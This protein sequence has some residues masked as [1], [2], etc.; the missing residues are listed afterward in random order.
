MKQEGITPTGGITMDAGGPVTTIVTWKIQEG[1]EQQF[2]AW[3]HEIEAAATKFPGH[4]GVNL[5]V[6][7][8]GIREYTV[9][10]RFDTIEHLR[11]W[12]ESD[13]R[14]D[15]LKKAERLQAT[16]PTYKTE[17]SLAYW[18]VTSKT[19]VPPSKWKMSVVTVLGVWPLSKLVPIVIGPIIKNM[20]P[21][22]SSF[23]VSVCI[24]SLLS[25]VVMPIFGKIFHPWLQNNRK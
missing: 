5:I 19:P 22:I 20:N 18:F 23:L 14:R 13:I 10:F 6:P 15:L 25:W 1:R 9:V 3:R 2:E 11:A 7:N 24:V 8:N 17:S 21:I 12:Q 4:M 16:N